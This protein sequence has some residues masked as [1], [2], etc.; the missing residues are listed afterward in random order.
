MTTFSCDV[1]EFQT[2]Y[3]DAYPHKWAIFRACDGN[4][5]DP[6][7]A[8]NL[9][10]AQ[11]AAKAGRIAGYTVYGV[12]EPGV[13][14]LGVIKSMVGEPD[15]HL[16][17][18]IDVERW[19]G[20]IT[21][22]HSGDINRFAE[23]TAA[24]LGDR[25]RVLLYANQGDYAELFPSRDSWLR[26]VV[27]GYSSNQ[28][29]FPQMI[30]WQYTDGQNQW[31]TPAGYPRSSAPFGACDHNAF[32]NHTPAQLAVALGVGGPPQIIGEFSVPIDP[33]AKKYLDSQFAAL[34]G[35]LGIIAHGDKTHL[36]SL[37][38]L[39][40]LASQQVVALA[41]PT[42]GVVVQIAQLHATVAS[43]TACV[44]ALA[45]QVKATEAARAAVSVTPTTV[46]LVGTLTIGGK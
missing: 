38:R 27:A 34:A 5:R 44:T 13:D 3:T 22:N 43:L 32:P 30:G 1:S 9:R 39:N 20:K 36:S 8:A 12:Y 19:G 42:H 25:R 10:W 2:V 40:G 28:P 35:G 16:T 23:A 45:G 41:D 26:C 15:R 24:W 7:F 37:D 17:V 6:H 46:P 33:E 21:G 18:M 31:P 4:Y 11:G 14:T 29:T